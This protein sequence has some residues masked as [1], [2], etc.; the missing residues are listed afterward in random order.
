MGAKVMKIEMKEK[1]TLALGDIL[2]CIYVDL[3]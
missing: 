2:K 1:S 3:F